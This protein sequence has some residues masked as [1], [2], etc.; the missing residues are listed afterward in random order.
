[1]E[2]TKS[3]AI[4]PNDWLF[5]ILSSTMTTTLTFYIFQFANRISFIQSLWNSDD[6]NF[7]RTFLILQFV[8]GV[9]FYIFLK[10]I[11][12]RMINYLLIKKLDKSSIKLDLAE[13]RELSKT[14]EFLIGLF[15]LR[16]LNS[17]EL[18]TIEDVSAEKD[19]LIKELTDDLSKWTCLFIQVAI[20]LIL[21]YKLNAWYILPLLIFVLMLILLFGIAVSIFLH[22]I[23]FLKKIRCELIMKD[24][25]LNI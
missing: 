7:I 6:K 3:K 15:N 24:K 22:S 25:R 4:I 8:T 2:Q 10:L 16:I 19:K 12:R 21:V 9:G 23:S 11:F 18:S 20:N 1:M 17:L 13:L 14:K 5:K